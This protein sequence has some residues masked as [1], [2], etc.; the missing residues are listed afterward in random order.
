MCVYCVRERERER[1]ESFAQYTA[2]TPMKMMWM[3]SQK[4]EKERIQCIAQRYVISPSI[5]HE[6]MPLLSVHEVIDCVIP[7]S[8]GGA[9]IANAAV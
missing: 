9:A 8:A 2:R 5:V 1:D 7:A 6:E 3:A 4:K